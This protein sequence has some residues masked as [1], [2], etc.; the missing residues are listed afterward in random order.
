LQISNW[1]LHG[2]HSVERERGEI[3]HASKQ[4]GTDRA[5]LAASERGGGRAGAGRMCQLGRKAEG[6][7]FLRFF[8]FSFISEF[9][10]LFS[11]ESKLKHTTYS[12]EIITSIC[13]T[14]GKI[15]GFCMLPHLIDTLR[16]YLLKRKNKY[17]SN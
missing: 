9:H 3:E 2:T 17:N 10:S 15:L 5:G 11:F 12:K 7:G 13:I 4:G 1:V 8:P 16:F 6:E 14:Q